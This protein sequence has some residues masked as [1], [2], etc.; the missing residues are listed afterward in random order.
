MTNPELIQHAAS[1]LNSQNLGGFYVGDV[2]CALI[3]ENNEV[4]TGACVGGGLGICAEQSAVSQ[5]ITKGKPHIKKIVA[6]WKDEH[7]ELYVIPPCGRCRDFLRSVSQDNL[8][9]EVILGK[10]HVAKLED[11]LPYHGWH[12]E[13]AV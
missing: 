5:M 9:A 4:F 2:G 10:D 6:V 7:G 3:S 8:E 13:K 12:A 11:L 1:A